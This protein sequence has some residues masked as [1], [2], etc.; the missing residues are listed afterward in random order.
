[1][2]NP[3]WENLVDL[4]RGCYG[5]LTNLIAFTVLVVPL[6]IMILSII[7]IK[8]IIPILISIGICGPGGPIILY[9]ITH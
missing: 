6:F 3:V 5:I 7:V 4:I 9:F 1:M 8:Y 2:G